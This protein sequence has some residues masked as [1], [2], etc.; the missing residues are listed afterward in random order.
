[1]G[2]FFE[3]FL[4]AEGRARVRFPS[5]SVDVHQIDVG[6]VV[7]FVSAE[8]GPASG[9]SLDPDG[10]LQTALLEPAVGAQINRLS[11]LGVTASMFFDES[12]KVIYVA[13]KARG[14]LAGISFSPN[15]DDDTGNYDELV[16]TGLVYE[17]YWQQN[18]MRIGGT[19]AYASGAHRTGQLAVDD[20]H[21]II[22]GA[23][24]T[25]HDDLTLAAS[26]TYNGSS[27][28]PQLPGI[29]AA[30]AYGYALSANYNRGPWTVGSFFQEARSEGDVARS[31]ADELKAFEIGGSYRFTTRTRVYSALYFYDFNDEGGR[32]RAD[33][34]DGYVFMLGMRFTL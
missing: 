15:A 10:G 12:P 2:D 14:F 16:Q 9:A 24:L 7:Q 8:F 29:A 25:L 1:M 5:T 31:G 32:V 30:T 19:Y 21:S 11:S 3:E 22:G 17:K 13:P 18:V 33:T 20:L 27:G 23:S 26:F 4:V 28:L 34:H 6:A